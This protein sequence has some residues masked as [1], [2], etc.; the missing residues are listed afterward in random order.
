MSEIVAFPMLNSLLIRGTEEGI[1]KFIEFIKLIDRKPQQIVIEI[2]S[3]MVSSNL[4]KEYGFQWFY[5]VGNFTIQPAPIFTS[6]AT[7][8]IGYG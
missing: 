5:N 8:T 4:I 2:Q 3:V 6:G 7:V 1:D